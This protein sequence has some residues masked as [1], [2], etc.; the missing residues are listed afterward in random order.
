MCNF[1]PS[2]PALAAPLGGPY[3]VFRTPHLSGQPPG[4]RPTL[5]ETHKPRPGQEKAFQHVQWAKP[6]PHHSQHVAAG[7]KTLEG[8]RKR[9]HSHHTALKPRHHA[10][11]WL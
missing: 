5:P 3:P 11:S 8:L 4:R 7:L 2:N 9:D 10:P 6:N 1:L